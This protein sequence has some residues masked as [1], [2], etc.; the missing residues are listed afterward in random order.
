MIENTVAMLAPEFQSA[1]NFLQVFSA[2]PPPLPPVDLGAIN[3]PTETE[4]SVI[5][6]Y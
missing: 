6:S 4:L 2:P 5:L 3:N 1:L